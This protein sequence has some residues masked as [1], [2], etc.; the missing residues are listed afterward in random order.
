MSARAKPP[1]TS[2]EA[3]AAGYRPIANFAA[4]LASN[5]AVAAGLPPDHHAN[6]LAS[7]ANPCD[8]A[9]AGKVCLDFTDGD[10]NHFIGVCDGH[11]V[12]QTHLK[13]KA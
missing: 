8:G 2:A 11:G 1:K 3:A 13:T 9:P 12:C 5:P 7:G 10:G 4:Y 6:A